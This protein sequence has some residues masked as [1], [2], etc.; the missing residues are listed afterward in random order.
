MVSEGSRACFLVWKKDQIYLMSAYQSAY[1]GYRY[2]K[3]MKAFAADNLDAAAIGSGVRDALLEFYV[4]TNSERESRADAIDELSKGRSKNFVRHARLVLV[5]RKLV[6][7]RGVFIV[8]GFFGY[9]G[10]G[11]DGVKGCS[12]T[13]AESSADKEV[14]DTILEMFARIDR[15]R[16]ITC[17]T[18]T[19]FFPP[20]PSGFRGSGELDERN[21]YD[22][23]PPACAVNGGS[24]KA[25]R[26]GRT[27]CWARAWAPGRSRCRPSRVR[28]AKSYPRSA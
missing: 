24:W 20:A 27:R 9:S 25:R 26:S 11:F 12:M 18:S 15:R 1:G 5:F 3:V 10:T 28:S 14:G 23:A 21:V 19:Q 8:E 2:G 7:A 6:D 16:W 17:A 22:A 13:I 4:S